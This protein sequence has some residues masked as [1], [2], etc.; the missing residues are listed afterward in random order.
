MP[1]HG[2]GVAV[3]SSACSN[4]QVSIGRRKTIDLI[5]IIVVRGSLSS[6]M[7]KALKKLH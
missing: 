4:T 7:D 2:T 3:R 6:S 1:P 5:L